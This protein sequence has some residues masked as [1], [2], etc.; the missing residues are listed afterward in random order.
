[1]R[2]R[3]K[4]LILAAFFLVLPLVASFQ[5]AAIISTTTTTKHVPTAAAAGEAGLP[6]SEDTDAVRAVVMA[7]WEAFNAYDVDGVFSYLEDN[8]RQQDGDKLKREISQLKNGFLLL[9]N[10]KLKVE[11]ESPPV[12][13]GDG[14]AE[15]MVR[16][17]T[18]IGFKHDYF[19]LVK[20]GDEWKI[21]FSEER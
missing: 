17:G 13:I 7:Y 14:E 11:E 16:L 5:S 19:R 21:S 18:P 10:V 1:M 8:W 6:S 15:M 2:S 9:R 20:I 3:T 4:F 12:L